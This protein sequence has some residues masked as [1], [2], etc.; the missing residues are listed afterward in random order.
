MARKRIAEVVS[1]GKVLV[2]DGAWGTFLQKKGMK[3]G[4]CPELWN[5][6]KF[7]DVKSIAQSYI[8]AGADMV[9]TDSFG[10]TKYKLEHYL[11]LLEERPRAVMNA[12]PVREANLPG[13]IRSFSLLLE[14]PDRSMVKLLRLIVVRD[15]RELACRK[16]QHVEVAVAGTRRYERDACPVRRV[17]RAR[18]VRVVRHEQ[19][20]VTTA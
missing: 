7:D 9:E 1:S 2:S 18:F 3:P 4:E 15:A 16:C 14:D 10:G 20:C 12:R 6:E 5:V 8:D 17:E 13:D 11:P 19:S